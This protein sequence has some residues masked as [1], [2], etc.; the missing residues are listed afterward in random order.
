MRERVP[1]GIFLWSF[2]PGGTE[3]QTIELIRRLSRERFDVHVACFHREGAWLPRAEEF[4]ASLTAFPIA[5]FRRPATLVQARAFAQWC[6]QIGVKIVYTADLY[7]NVFALPAAAMAGVPVRIGSRREINP[8]KTTGQI[9]LQRAAYSCAHRIVA[10]CAAAAERLVTERLPR[11]RIEVIP[12]GVDLDLHG[13]RAGDRPIRRIATVANLRAEKGH[14]VLFEAMRVVLRRCPESELVVAGE[15]PLRQELEALARRLEIASS[16]RF[17]GHCDNVPALLAECDAFVLA[18]RSEAFPNSVL[19]AM[20]SSLP[21]VATRVGGIREVIEHQ[22]TG[23][24]V[25]PDDPGA[26]AYALLDLIQWEGH[27]VTLGRAARR[28]VEARYSFGRMVSAFER[29]YLDQLA[30]HAVLTPATSEVIAS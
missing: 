11:E 10:N 23:V 25:P 17:V 16:I 2:Q 30:R 29:L 1:I 14:D 9:A 27:A 15:G 8:N 12:N 22:R 4:A 28:A 24:L 18:S 19:E 7:A 6:R 5:G 13:A 21:I 26:L 20:A 3:R